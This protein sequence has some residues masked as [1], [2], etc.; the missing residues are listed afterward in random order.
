MAE[1]MKAQ[2]A[3][4]TPPPTRLDRLRALV[5]RLIDVEND[6]VALEREIEPLNDDAHRLIREV[7]QKVSDGRRQLEDYR[8]SIGVWS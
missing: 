5:R 6:L 8:D 4:A 2:R 1:T 7:C 3:L